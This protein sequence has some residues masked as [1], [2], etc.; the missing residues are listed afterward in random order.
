MCRPETNLAA[1][2]TI[3]WDGDC[4][5]MPVVN[6]EGKVVGMITDRDISIA[7]ATKGRLAS[8]IPVSE[9]ITG[10]AY[11]CELDED[12]KS[13]LKT[14]R[15]ERVRRLPVINDDGR[16]QGILC[17]N[18]VILRAEEARGKHVPEISYEDVMSTMKALC[19]HRPRAASAGA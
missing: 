19:E 10:K 7:L 3:M 4:G 2:A 13:A 1:V 18:D 15:H 9:V 14:M 8:E 12:I 17:M 16:L 11:S 6:E 5:V